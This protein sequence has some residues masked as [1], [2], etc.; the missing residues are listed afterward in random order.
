MCGSVGNI[1]GHIK[2]IYSVWECGKY[3]R[4]AKKTQIV[5]GS[6]GNIVGQ[7]KNIYS[8]CECVKYCRPAKKHL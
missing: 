8:V 2:N 5:C 7:L 4:P 3:C 6:V 1:V